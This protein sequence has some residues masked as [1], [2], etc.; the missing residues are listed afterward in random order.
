MVSEGDGEGGSLWFGHGSLPP[1]LGQ[2]RLVLRNVTKLVRICQTERLA[3]GG[4][5]VLL[6]R[7]PSAGHG[8]WTVKSTW[9]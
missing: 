6:C 1:R 9:R 4:D 5:F 2:A 8:G 3:G 7:T